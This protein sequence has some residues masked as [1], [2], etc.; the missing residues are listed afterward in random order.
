MLPE[1]KLAQRLV[2][3]RSLVP[4]ID[5]LGLLREFA[6]VEFVTFPFK[7]K[8]DGLCLDLKAVGKRP[9]VLVNKAA[10]NLRQRFTLAHELGHV[11]IP[12][13]VGQIV[14]QIDLERSPETDYFDVESQANR[15]ASELLMPT[16][17]VQRQLTEHENPLQAVLFVANKAEVSWR[18]AA[19]KVINDLPPNYVIASCV[20][21]MVDW[22]ARSEGT[23]V[24]K[25]HQETNLEI[26][27]PYRF[28]CQKWTEE[29]GNYSYYMWHFLPVEQTSLMSQANWRE[30]LDSM[31]AQIIPAEIDQKRFKQS[32]NGVSSAANGSVRTGKTLETIATAIFHALHAR[33]MTEW[34]YR[35]LVQHP[36][37]EAFYWARAKSYLR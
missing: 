5:I 12:W 35:G 26:T 18:A 9:T 29:R 4:R 31:V 13:H 3:R 14:D 25:V 11:L 27:D 1:E 22:S 7:F 30:I 20:G 10:S 32:I 15:F 16:A 6:E 17:W 34:Q 33:A 21:R 2:Q 19:I 37:F 23:R 36:E 8:V 24:A 28:P